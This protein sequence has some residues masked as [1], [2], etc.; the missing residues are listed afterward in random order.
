M[1]T[2]IEK[3]KAIEELWRKGILWWK[4]FPFQK[5]LYNI[6]QETSQKIVVWACSRRSGKTRTVLV[7]AF[8]QCLKKPNSIV[9]FIAPQQAMIRKIIKPMIRELLE[10]CPKD[11]R[12]I[13][14]TQDNTWK[15]PNG[16]E[17]Q[18][19]GTDNGNV[20]SLRGGNANLCIVDE[21]GFCDE[22]SYAVN[23]VLMP[24]LATTRGKLIMVSTPPTSPDHDFVDFIKT[25]K[26]KGAYA[27]K[28]LDDNTMLSEQEKEELIDAIGGR[29]SIAVR[30]EYYVEIIADT[31]RAIV[32]EFDDEVRSVVIKDIDRPP[33]FDAYV[34]MDI[35]VKDLT[36]ALF[37]YLDFRNATLV[38]EDEFVINGPDMTTDKL[39]RGIKAK[40][41]ALWKNPYTG[42]QKTPYIRISDNNLLLIQDLSR[43]HN[44]HFLPTEKK[45]ADSALN[46]LRMLVSSKKIIISPKCTNLI[47]H[48]INGTWNKNRSSYERAVDQE[49]RQHH[50]DAIDALSYLV[51]NV[52]WTKNPY[53]ANYDYPM[54]E[55][56]LNPNYSEDLSRNNMILKSI[57]TKK[58]KI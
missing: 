48:L 30:R 10:D 56:F 50:Y 42:D 28:T 19:A 18:L 1:S 36:V 58:Y 46:Q 16:S 14:H 21:A 23:S 17:I 9:K 5:D 52:N 8:E 40:E 32:P 3:I 57:F 35:G 54:G 33:Y 43:I 44:L 20:E 38:I 22:L 49:S 11:L 39:A 25:A 55:I 12:P 15:F 27:Q 37:A 7:I 31:A 45:N 13:Y 47:H 4:L 41:E 2:K 51:R 6:Y 24:T 29:D 53:P 34:S 26:L